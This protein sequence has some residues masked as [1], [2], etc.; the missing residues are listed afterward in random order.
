ML[1][2]KNKVY[3]PLDKQK[4]IWYKLVAERTGEIGKLDNSVQF[5]KIKYNFKGP[6]KDLYLNGFIDGEIVFYYINSKKIK[7]IDAEGNPMTFK[8]K[9]SSA[10]VGDNK[11]DKQ[12]SDAENITKS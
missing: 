11:S 3:L 2:K 12:L 10:I 4:E 1:K 7:F 8:S 5:E 6:T 9:L